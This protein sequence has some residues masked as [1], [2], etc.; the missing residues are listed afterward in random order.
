MMPAGGYRGLFDLTGRAA[1]V[2]GACGII[3]RHLAAALAEFGAPVALADLDG[4]AAAAL[5]TEI[6]ARTDTPAIGVA[7][8]VAD[9]DSVAALVA[10]T[11]DELG[12]VRILANNA[13]TKTGDLAA[14][15]APPEDYA[16]DTWRAVNAVNLDGAFLMAQAAGRAMIAHGQGGSIVTTA[17][18][19]GVLG[20]DNRIYEGSHYNGRPISTPPVYAASKAGVL[21]LTRYLACVW[22]RHGIRVN[23]ITPGGV[24]SGQND[25]FLD[26]Y[27]ARVPLG[28]MA[29]AEDMTGALVWLAS[30]AAAYVTGQNLAVDGG[31]TAW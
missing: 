15:L 24:D 7:C 18:I 22:A 21:G 5:A 29:R 6:A 26:R 17:S 1:I 28:R 3:G 10:R 20:P 9:P 8:D 25:A 14:F 16:L 12:P 23:A 31:L 30:D 4:A 2:T 11:E 13:A 27:S 19:Y